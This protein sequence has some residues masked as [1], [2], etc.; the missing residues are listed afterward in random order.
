[1]YILAE[2]LLEVL[3]EKPDGTQTKVADLAPGTFFGEK[4]LLTGEP[5]SATIVC[6]AESI[7]CE[8][9]KNCM[10]TLLERKP[11]LAETFARAVIERD[12]HNER[13]L[14]RAT[15]EEVEMKVTSV[16]GQFVS[17]I[18]GFFKK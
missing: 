11:E 8:I 15:K 18:R 7:V 9:T 12:L 16:V 2:G 3:I 17:K 5:R 4:S 14:S 1:M 10:A 6:V 13:T